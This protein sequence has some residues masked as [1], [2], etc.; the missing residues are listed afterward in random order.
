M[1]NLVVK[2]TKDGVLDED[3]FAQGLIEFR[4]TPRQSGKSP[5]EILYGREI[6][7]L[8]PQIPLKDSWIAVQNR[9]DY[10][11]KAEDNYNT[12]AKDL[13]PIAIGKEVY[14]QD[15]LSL[16]WDRT[17]TIVEYLGRRSYRIRLPSGRTLI[18]NRRFLRPMP[19]QKQP[20][21]DVVE[22]EESTP[23]RSDTEK[24]DKTPKP[25]PPEATTKPKAKAAEEEPR[26]S[27]RQTKRPQRYL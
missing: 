20:T 23:K 14:V 25:K 12:T 10:S 18:R 27:K 7:S 24:E 5:A 9:H 6:R 13:K 4:N 11:R 2:C 21:T 26:R 16:R 22:K 8:V 17:G 3:A 1:K 19:V 15:D